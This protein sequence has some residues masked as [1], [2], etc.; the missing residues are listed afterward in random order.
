MPNGKNR[1]LTSPL[2]RFKV[3]VK[4]QVQGQRSKAK[5][6][7]QRSR[8]DFWHAA[9]DI[10]GPTLPR[11]A[12]SN[13]KSHYQSKEFVCVSVIMGCISCIW[14]MVWMQFCFHCRH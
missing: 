9:V 1:G 10:R 4:S 14:T 8:F 3:K 6:M 11:A 2:P 7:G 12:K 5:V 13:Y